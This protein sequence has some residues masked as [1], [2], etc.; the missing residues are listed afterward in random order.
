MRKIKASDEL[1]QEL[2]RQVVLDKHTKVCPCKV[3]TRAAIKKA[4]SEGATT[5]EEVSKL[6]GACTGSCKGRRC[7]NKVEELIKKYK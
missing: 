3:V 4:I 1:K 7:K 6:T 5:V 2:L